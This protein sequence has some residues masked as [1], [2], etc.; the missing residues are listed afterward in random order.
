MFHRLWV[1]LD[2]E[3]AELR[4]EIVDPDVLQAANEIDP[5]SCSMEDWILFTKGLFPHP[6]DLHPRP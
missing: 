4:Q 3:V 1:C 5:A 2:P 6:G